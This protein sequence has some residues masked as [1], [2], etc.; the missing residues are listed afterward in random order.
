[1]AAAHFP[2][3]RSESKE[4]CA[5]GEVARILS[6][7]RVSTFAEYALGTRR[8]HPNS[9]SRKACGWNLAISAVCRG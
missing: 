5:G 4:N 9:F 6:A 1:M 8:C 7:K 3:T 2:A